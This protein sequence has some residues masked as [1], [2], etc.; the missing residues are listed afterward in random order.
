MGLTVMP[1]ATRDRLAEAALT[2]GEVGATAGELP[3]GYRHLTRR[4]L[5]GRGHQLF[6]DAAASK[7]LPTVSRF[8]IWRKLKTR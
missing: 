1:A 8:R 5:I 4:V 2:Y 6:A 3:A 7:R